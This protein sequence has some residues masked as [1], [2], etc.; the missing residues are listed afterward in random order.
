M[1]PE[2][3]PRC[4]RLAPLLEEMQLL[5]TRLRE[6]MD[7]RNRSDVSALERLLDMTAAMFEGVLGPI[8]PKGG[9]GPKS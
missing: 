5:R 3:C 7:D 2:D 4:A 8:Q 6:G 9:K 1:N